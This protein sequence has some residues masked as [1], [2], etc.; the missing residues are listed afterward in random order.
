MF[1]L[2]ILVN[3][4]GGWTLSPMPA[5]GFAH[6]TPEQVA[7]LLDAALAQVR[8]NIAPP[9]PIVLPDG[10]EATEDGV[11]VAVVLGGATSHSRNYRKD[12][13]VVEAPCAADG[14]PIAATVDA[15]NAA[16]AAEAVA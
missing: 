1:A 4:E 8:A 10:W 13:V 12:G 2:T 7:I 16:G 11:N 3:P 9:A 6:P 14:S 5:P 15:L